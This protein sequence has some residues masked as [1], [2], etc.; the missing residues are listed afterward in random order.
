MTPEE[1]KKAVD[2]MVNKLRAQGA[3]ESDGKKTVSTGERQWPEEGETISI[4]TDATVLDMPRGNGTMT[5]VVGVTDEG[6]P[7]IISGSSLTKRIYLVNDKGERVNEA[8]GRQKVL[9]ACGNV[10]ELAH[11]CV[12]QKELLTK[13]IGKKLHYSNQQ[14]GQQWNRFDKKVETASVFQIDLV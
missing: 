10:T 11:T 2:L 6:E 8:D 9:K 4:P 3:H 5:F 14:T 13:L 1:S 12:T 7:R